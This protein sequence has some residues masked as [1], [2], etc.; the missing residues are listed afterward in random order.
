MIN[1]VTRPAAKGK[2][3]YLDLSAYQG[4]E[5]RVRAGV[6]GG[7]N[8][9]RGSLSLM[10]AKFDG[11]VT[12][13]ADGSKVNGYDRDGVRAR[14]EFLP[15]KDLKVTVIADHTRSIDTTPTGV[16]YGT[17]V[18]TYPTNA[19]TANPLFAAAVA[20]VVPSPTNTQINSEMR[21]RVRDTNRGLSAQV[22]YTLPAITLTSIT[23][24]R[25][26]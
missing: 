8:E 16:A 15:T 17:N 9:L 10:T 21:T 12:N 14:V 26:W 1:I 20:P 22:D 7:S 13:V 4:G 2:G 24:Q 3:G 19:V 25:G 23:A 18:T 5:H 6:F 11:N